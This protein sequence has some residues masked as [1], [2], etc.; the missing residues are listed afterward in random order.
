MANTPSLF[1]VN[2]QGVFGLGRSWFYLTLWRGTPA[3][4][5]TEAST[6]I[7]KST[8]AQA[9]IAAAD[10]AEASISRITTAV[11]DIISMDNFNMD[12]TT[13]TAVVWYVG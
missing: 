9:L 13:E 2:Q 6:E 5:T 10:A 3:E 4:F 1:T 11:T 12:I 8:P 7:Q